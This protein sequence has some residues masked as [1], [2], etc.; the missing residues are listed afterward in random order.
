MTREARLALAVIAVVAVCAALQSAG[1][2]PV[3]RY[4]RTALGS[5][6]LW[7]LLSGNLVHLGTAHLAL[8]AAGLALVALLVGRLLPLWAWGL[9]LLLCALAVGAGLWAFAPGVGWYVGLSGVLHGLLAAGAA[10]ALWR[11]SER[12][13]H[14][15]LLAVLAAKLG[16]EQLAGGLPGTAWL[17][18][19]RVIVDAHLFGA[20]GGLFACALLLPLRLRSRPPRTA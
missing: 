14:A 9:V 17:A 16:W 6:E 19:G 12:G 18:D 1:L 3:L 20:I 2:V 7:R 13:F 8:N 4:D 11:G 15:L 10:H 5:G